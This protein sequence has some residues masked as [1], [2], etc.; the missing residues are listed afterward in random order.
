MSM[1]R[2]TPPASFKTLGQAASEAVE[3]VRLKMAARA[4]VHRDCEYDGANIVIPCTSH[5]E[6][7]RLVADL[8]A[9]LERAA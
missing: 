3:I 6:A 2:P 9:A 8:R 4:L 5:A 1:T 7:I